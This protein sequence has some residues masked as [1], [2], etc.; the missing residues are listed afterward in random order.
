MKVGEGAKTTYMYLC[1]Y[2]DSL[3]I[4]SY[5]CGMLLNKP[6]SPSTHVELSPTKLSTYLW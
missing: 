2:L 6:I 5:G 3:Y 4:D 1:V